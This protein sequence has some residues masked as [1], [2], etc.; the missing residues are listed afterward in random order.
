MA[1]AKVVDPARVQAFVCDPSYSSKLLMDDFV[2]GTPAINI[3]EGT[4]KGGGSTK[5]GVHEQN[6]LYYCVRGEAVLHLGDESFD[7]KP[8]MVAFIPGGTRHALDNKS[9]TEDFVLLTFW[10][11]ADYNG[12]HHERIKAWGTSFKTIDEA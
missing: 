5:A 11:K 7:F 6:E 12:V 3:N 2:A 10:E 1:E 9:D 4:L 8:G